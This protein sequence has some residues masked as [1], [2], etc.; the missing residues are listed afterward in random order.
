MLRRRTGFVLRPGQYFHLHPDV[1]ST[2][3][4]AGILQDLWK[5][6][7]KA[8]TNIVFFTI[9]GEVIKFWLSRGQGWCEL[10][11]CNCSPGENFLKSGQKYGP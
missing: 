9:K 8:G 4:H 2:Q 6:L 1:R 10:C 11:S 3:G 5:D 7:S